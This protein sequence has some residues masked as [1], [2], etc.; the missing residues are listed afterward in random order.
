[1]NLLEVR[2]LRASYVVGKARIRVIDN[3][4]FTVNEG[5]RVAVVGE[6]GSGKSTLALILCKLHDQNLVIEGGEIRYR[7]VNLLELGSDELRKLR[8]SEI[9]MVFQNPSTSLNP[10][11]PVGEQVAEALRERGYSRSEAREIAVKLL[12]RV[13]IPEARRRYSH[14]PH[15]LSG[16]MKQRVMIAMAIALKP[17][18][19]IADEPTSALDVSIQAQILELLKELSQEC[20]TAIL[21]ITHD[22]GVAYDV[23][24][25]LIVMYA[26]KVV[27][28]GSTADIVKE[29]L[30]PYTYYLLASIPRGRKGEYEL[31]VLEGYVPDLLNP[32]PGCRFHPRCPN[33]INGLCNIREPPVTHVNGRLVACHQYTSYRG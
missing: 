12:E 6:S 27:E 7:G 32:P 21:L 20:G 24:S 16:G 31:K 17:K 28:V 18:L 9:A 26:G 3:V 13:G 14:Y 1:M 25:K 30:H 8:G 33:A 4:S 19:L 11:Y 10:V 29:P 15:Q 2:S 5:E 22:I 23:S